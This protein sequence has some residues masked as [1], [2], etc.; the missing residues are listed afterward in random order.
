VPQA[1]TEIPFVDQS[2]GWYVTRFGSIAAS[3]D[4]G[5]SWRF[6]DSRTASHLHGIAFISDATGWVAGADETVLRT[7]TGECLE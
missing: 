1:I 6:Q 7:T 4:G 2:T 5:T 3:T